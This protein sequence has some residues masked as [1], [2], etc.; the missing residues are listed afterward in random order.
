L[1]AA[2]GDISLCVVAE[3]EVESGFVQSGRR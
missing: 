1:R 2:A 3:A